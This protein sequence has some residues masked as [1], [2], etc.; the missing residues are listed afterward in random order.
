MGGNVWEWQANYYSDDHGRLGLRGGA[1]SANHD[2]A[3]ATSRYRYSPHS[4]N[5]D[6]G[7][8]VVLAAPFSPN[9]DL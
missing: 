9:S 3:R 7:V 2:S 5:G 6:I 4:P 8:R 1:F